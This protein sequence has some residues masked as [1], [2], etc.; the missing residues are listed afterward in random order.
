M[1]F[2]RNIGVAV[3]FLIFM[4][5]AMLVGCSKTNISEDTP[6]TEATI[7]NPSSSKPTPNGPMSIKYVGNSCFYLTFPDGTTFLT[8]PY[9]A[10]FKAFF[11]PAPDIEVNAYT[12]SHYHEDHAPDL[13]QLKGEPQRLVPALMKEPIQV[14]EV[15]VTGFP[16]KHVS[17][18]GDNEIFVFRFGDFKI[19]HMGETD[20]IESLEAL[21]AIKNADVVLT[22]AGEYGS[23]TLNNT[24]IFQYLYDMNVKVLIPQHF[25]NNPDAIFYG[26]PT[27]DEILKQVPQGVKT[28]KLDELVVT[29]DM[30]KQFVELSQMNVE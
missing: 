18:L 21:D 16:S 25:S 3:L 12:V 13:K 1:N 7:V 2:K 8:D 4:C 6:N 10:K 15:E 29:K 14:G 30:K 19:V 9:P 24:D 20:K 11:G 22:Y 17:N 5:C 27:I 28:V 26:E 23:E